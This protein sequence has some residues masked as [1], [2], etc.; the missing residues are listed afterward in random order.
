MFLELYVGADTNGS[1]VVECFYSDIDGSLS[2]T[3]YQQGVARAALAWLRD[4]GARRLPPTERT[5]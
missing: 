1:P 4:E 2:I 5:V 3:E